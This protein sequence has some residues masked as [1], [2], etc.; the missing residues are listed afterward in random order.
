MTWLHLFT[1]RTHTPYWKWFR[2]TNINTT[3]IIPVHLMCHLST[4]MA[5][6]ECGHFR[7]AL[8]VGSFSW[9]S[10]LLSIRIFITLLV[11]MQHWNYWWASVCLC[12]RD[13]F[14]FFFDS[15]CVR[16]HILFY[17]SIYP[18]F[19]VL[20][21]IRPVQINVISLLVPCWLCPA[22]NSWNLPIS[23]LMYWNASYHRR[24]DLWCHIS[25]IDREVNEIPCWWYHF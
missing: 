9:P 2:P 6:I 8:L 19:F 12:V 24:V 10:K 21:P 7:C 25:Y 15:L 14:S 17:A 23:F 11:Y 20:I 3:A 5:A 13:I 16:P 18:T 1:T 22:E 4:L